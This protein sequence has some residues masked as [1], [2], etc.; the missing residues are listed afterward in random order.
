M[1]LTHTTTTITREEVVTTRTLAPELLQPLEPEIYV[2]ESGI[3]RSVTLMKLL[4]YFYHLK[5]KSYLR[6][7]V[8]KPFQVRDS[9]LR[10]TNKTKFFS[11]GYNALL[12]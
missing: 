10:K 2:R 12:R 3:A 8:T 9:N 1:T 4:I 7:F 6:Y 11:C 5:L